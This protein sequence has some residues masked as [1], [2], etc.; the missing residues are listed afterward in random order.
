MRRL[1]GFRNSSEPVT[2]KTKSSS[3]RKNRWKLLP[4]RRTTCFTKKGKTIN[5]V[6]ISEEIK[7][8]GDLFMRKEI[9]FLSEAMRVWESGDGSRVEPCQQPGSEPCAK[10]KPLGCTDEPVWLNGKIECPWQKGPLA[11]VSDK[12]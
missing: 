1:R 12:A 7:K 11:I 10:L 4:R 3:Y 2:R 9:K 8:G 6:I 5:L